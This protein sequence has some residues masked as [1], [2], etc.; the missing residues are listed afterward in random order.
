MQEQI[1][2]EKIETPSDGTYLVPMPFSVPLSS[3]YAADA[4]STFSLKRDRVIESM[5][6]NNSPEF[7]TKNPNVLLTSWWQVFP[8]TTMTTNERLNAITRMTIILIVVSYLLTMRTRIL[9]IGLL[10]LGAIVVYYYVETKRTVEQ[11]TQEMDARVKR[12]QEAKQIEARLPSS[13]F[14]EPKSGNPFSNVLVTDYQ[15][16][17]NKKPAPPIDNAQVRDKVLDA[18]KQTVLDMNPTQPDLAD[19]LFKNMGD[20][21]DFEQSLRQFVTQPGT[22]IP[23]DQE[24]FSQFCY[25]SMISCKEGN[26]FACARNDPRTQRG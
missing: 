19:K 13:I 11:F 16:N 14:D 2:E 3:Q 7:W 8:D 23:N 9:A 25:G 26:A 21:W 5:G 17:V 22:T 6:S 10:T 1:K 20:E 18:A 24:A 15:Y 4:A 12:A